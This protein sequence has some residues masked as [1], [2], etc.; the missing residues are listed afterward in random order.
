[1]A[2][3]WIMETTPSN[4]YVLSVS[5]VIA[6]KSV[7]IFLFYAYLF[8]FV[9]SFF[10]FKG[11]SWRALSIRYWEVS[12]PFLRKTRLRIPFPRSSNSLLGGLTGCLGRWTCN[13][14]VPASSLLPC[15]LLGYYSV[16]PSS[17]PRLRCVNSQLVCLLPI[18]IF[19]H[20][21][22]SVTLTLKS[23]G[24]GTNKECTPYIKGFAIYYRNIYFHEWP[25][26]FY[27]YF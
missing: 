3:A 25:F 8:C 21:I 26:N 15:R 16:V 6:V 9:F 12:G 2:H 1:M 22:C 13:L 14:V 27:P 10:L 5:L 23:P 24:E 7:S 18:G 17:T 19:K 20:H 4:A 11:S